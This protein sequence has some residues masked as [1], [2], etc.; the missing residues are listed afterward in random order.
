MILPSEIAKKAKNLVIIAEG[1]VVKIIAQALVGR[2]SVP[3]TTGGQGRPP[4]L[5]PLI[6]HH[7]KAL[8]K[9]FLAQGD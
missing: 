9:S 5:N 6:Y 1:S 4:H 3:A 7:N 8:S 2:A